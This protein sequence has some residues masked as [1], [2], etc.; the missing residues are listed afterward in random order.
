DGRCDAG[1]PACKCIG[2]DA[3][4]G[5]DDDGTCTE[6]KTIKPP[7]PGWH[8][9]DIA[10]GS[11]PWTYITDEHDQV[12][13]QIGGG[14]DRMRSS[15]NVTLDKTEVK[16]IGGH[17]VLRIETTDKATSDYMDESNFD[18]GEVTTKN[19]TVCDIGDAN[20][21]TSCLRDI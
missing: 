7:V 15:S 12:V 18:Q 9:Y 4:L 19:I 8:V 14:E 21:P 2:E 17:Q 10:T 20:R 11:G 3:Q 13:A 1:T 5:E 6:S 16:T